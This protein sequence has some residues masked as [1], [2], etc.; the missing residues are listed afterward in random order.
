[1]QDSEE[2]LENITL[3]ADQQAVF[4]AIKNH[5]DK[6]FFIQGQAGTGKSLLIKYI[7]RY[8][9]R[10]IAIVAP[11]GIAAELIKGT[12]IHSLFK[13]GGRPYFPKN[14][15][16][17]YKQY[18]EVVSLIDTLI[19][20]EAS[21]LRADVFDTVDT[22][23]R[24]AKKNDKVF[25]GI[26]IVLVGDLYQLPPVYNYKADVAREAQYYMWNTYRFPEPFFFDAKCYSEGN[27]QK[28]EL[29]VPHRQKIDNF[30]DC[31]RTISKFNTTDNQNNVNKAIDVLNSRLNPCALSDDVPIVTSTNKKANRINEQKLAAIRQPERKYDGVF[32]GSFYEDADE[33]TSKQRRDSMLVPEHLILKVGA[34]VMLCCNDRSG[35]N[36]Y[37]NG[38]IGEVAEL[39]E[40]YIRVNIPQGEVCVYPVT[41]E[42]Q[43]YVKS[44]QE[45]GKLVLNTI[46]KYT[47]F[48]LKLAYAI[49]IHKSQG[50]TWDAVC[51]DLG[52]GGAFASGQTYV[53]L[54]RVKALAGVHLVKKLKSGDVKTNLRVQQ[55]LATGDVPMIDVPNR[56]EVGMK[57][58]WS[59]YFPQ[60]TSVRFAN[61]SKRR[62]GGR[63]YICFWFTVHV[64]DLQDDLYLICSDY[65]NN[66]SQIF[67]IQAESI[68]SED[69]GLNMNIYSTDDRKT[70]EE[71]RESHF[72]L[73]I[74]AG[75]EHLELFAGKVKFKPYLVAIEDN[76]QVTSFD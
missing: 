70:S 32:E 6:N 64:A 23:C 42:T 25:G 21:M 16:D 13:L 57:A 24:K 11:T 45:S 7:R 26:Q 67:K 47:Q 15:V 27:F 29:S 2:W 76:G 58:F 14:V 38:T 66:F 41:W 75:N 49:T 65:R 53:A 52:D 72:D 39:Q 48:P 34:R 3:D 50:Q 73:F 36:Q 33:R 1:M 18:D 8:L 40:D 35:N 12:T 31:L 30:L 54:S 43:E 63:D 4:D 17:E 59:G 22:L 74:E 71:Y 62:L 56:F 10:S 28:M 20:D 68:K 69:L 37:V 60:I 51:I 55:F 46:G 9:G 5:P 61:K 19:I 44:V